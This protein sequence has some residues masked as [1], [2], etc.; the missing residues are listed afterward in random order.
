MISPLALSFE[1]YHP[2]GIFIIQRF[3]TR[4]YR[5]GEVVGALPVATVSRNLHEPKIAHAQ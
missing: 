3:S 1:S 4:Q 5:V 2:P